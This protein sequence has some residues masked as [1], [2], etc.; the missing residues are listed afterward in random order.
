MLQSQ[1]FRDNLI[2]KT[3]GQQKED[4]DFQKKQL[5]NTVIKNVCVFSGQLQILDH[6]EWP[7]LLC[8]NQQP[9]ED[10]GTNLTK[11]TN[12]IEMEVEYTTFKWHPITIF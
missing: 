1:W 8:T 10:N 7:C 11:T 12:Q 3:N 6:S 4:Y 2:N 9:P 5:F